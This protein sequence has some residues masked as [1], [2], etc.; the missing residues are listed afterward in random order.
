MAAASGWLETSDH[1]GQ[2]GTVAEVNEERT[3]T[4][5]LLSELSAEVLR[6]LASEVNAELARRLLEGSDLAAITE[7]A[8]T[9][10]FDR[11]VNVEPHVTEDGL[12]VCPGVK[13]DRSSLSHECCF[14][15]IGENWSWEHPEKLHDEIRYIPGART[16]MRSI[17][18]LP[19]FEGL[20]FDVV[21]SKMR[22]GTHEM[23]QVR[24][25]VIKDGL[26]QIVATRTPRINRHR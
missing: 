3:P 13:L 15:H 20:E 17:T 10:S 19:A 11:G 2:G 23:R 26:A 4:W 18:I 25:Y 14:T 5:P 8:F 6:E 22:S 21:T 9:R 12:L 16:T 1:F 7:Q 24:S